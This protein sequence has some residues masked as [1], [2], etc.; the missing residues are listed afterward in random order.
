MFPLAAF[1]MPSPKKTVPVDATGTVAREALE[2]LFTRRYRGADL[3]AIEKVLVPVPV[4]IESIDRTIVRLPSARHYSARFTVSTDGPW[5]ELMQPG[6]TGKFVPG[7]YV[8]ANGIWRE[9]AKGRILAV[10]AEK[11]VASGE[12]YLGTSSTKATLEA[13]LPQLSTEDFLEIDQYG[14]A[15]KTLSALVEHAL[16][17]QAVSEGFVVRR[18]P[19][20]VARHIG[21]YYYYDYEFEREGV[22]KRIEVKSLWGT[23]TTCAR[24]IHSKG[25]GYETS[26]CKFST[27][28]IFAV[29][30]FLRTGDIRNF[31]FARSIPKDVKSYGLP[32]ASKFADYVNQ[33]PVCQIGDGTWFATI[34]EVWDL[35]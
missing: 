7:D 21:A 9:I 28:D 12:I 14:A 17:T 19:A 22:T 26:S 27:Q 24:L 25:G 23:N 4:P 31:A 13:V 30:L 20:D 11:G 34:S 2:R 5:R 15:A 35:D 32:R 1:R 10:D 33:N 29:N 8:T 3:E 6:C 16:A 18:M